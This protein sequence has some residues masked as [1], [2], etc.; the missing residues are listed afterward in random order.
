MEAKL[1]SDNSNLK[2]KIAI[3]E[4]SIDVLRNR[5]A[6][7]ERGP[8]TERVRAKNNSTIDVMEP[9]RQQPLV[10]SFLEDN[11]KNY[12]AA[13]RLNQSLQAKHLVQKVPEL[14]TL[15]TYQWGKPSE[16]KW[17]DAKVFKESRDVRITGVLVWYTDV[18]LGMRFSY[19]AHSKAIFTDEHVVLRTKEYHKVQLE[20]TENDYLQNMLLY[21]LDGKLVGIT[22]S[23]RDSKVFQVG[24][25]VGKSV[26]LAISPTQVP[27]YAFG[28]LGAISDINKVERHSIVSSLGLQ[29]LAL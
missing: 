22:F 3:L 9:E 15:Q 7:R 11:D 12:R 16:R 21:E 8:A 5:Q 20:F 17:S 1:R 14:Q 27:V 25:Q 4:K 13:P 26:D 19:R 24:R 29:T 23:S 18:I 6:S 2:G 28:T 10:S